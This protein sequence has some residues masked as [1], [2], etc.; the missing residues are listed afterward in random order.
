MRWFHEIFAKNVWE[1]ISVISTLWIAN[2]IF[3][4]Q[5]DLTKK[6]ISMKLQSF[7]IIPLRFT[8]CVSIEK[9]GSRFALTLFSGTC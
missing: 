2:S 3:L 6:S 7:T 9:V 4:I 5:V 8:F 1:R